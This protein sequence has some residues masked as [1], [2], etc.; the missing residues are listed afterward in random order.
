M[1]GLIV[2]LDAMKQR[3]GVEEVDKI[4]TYLDDYVIYHFEKEEA[5]MEEYG[6]SGYS[7]HKKEHK[8]FVN[9]LSDIK[10]EIGRQRG[11]TLTIAIQIQN[12]VC[13]WLL[14]HIGDV[15][16]KLGAFF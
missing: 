16:K 11:I 14:N 15:D 7:F 10:K 5:C 8:A 13:D 12:S 6:Y 4:I 1:I 2:L 3:K 9:G